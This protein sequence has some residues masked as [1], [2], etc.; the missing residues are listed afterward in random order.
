MENLGG[1]IKSMPRTGPFLVGA[2]AIG[3]LPPFNGF[4][5]E[6]LIYNGLIEGIHTSSISQDYTVRSRFSRI[7][8]H[9]R[10]FGSYL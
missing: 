7:K 4:V 3:G 1:L 9:R 8:Y 2:L 5:S 6:F 10:T